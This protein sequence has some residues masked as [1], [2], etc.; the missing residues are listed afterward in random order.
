MQ[1]FSAQSRTWIY[2]SNRSFT[3]SE[4]EQLQTILTDFTIRW[5]AHNQQLHAGYE[6]RYDQFIVLIVDENNTGASGCSIDKSVRVIQTIEQE[7][8]VELF[9]RFSMAY[10]NNSGEINTVSREEFEKL[11]AEEK[12]NGETIVFNNLVQTYGELISQWEI[13]LAQS[14]HAR[15]FSYTA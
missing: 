2:Q 15:V 14:W 9:N 8:G 1:N 10:R 6:L 3:A 7:F 4:L 13:P 5:T 11:L 12:I